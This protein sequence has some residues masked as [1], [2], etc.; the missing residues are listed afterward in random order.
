MPPLLP[1]TDGAGI[2]IA[3]VKNPMSMVA[4]GLSPNPTKLLG[5]NT[6]V[7]VRGSGPSTP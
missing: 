7:G 6:A 2:G 4:K 3:P 1:S 5:E